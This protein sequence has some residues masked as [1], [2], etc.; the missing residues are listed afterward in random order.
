MQKHVLFYSF[1]MGFPSC[2]SD[3]R[4]FSRAVIAFDFEK[5]SVTKPL[6]LLLNHFVVVICYWYPC[7]PVAGFPQHKDKEPGIECIAVS[8]SFMCTKRA[9]LPPAVD[10][11]DAFILPRSCPYR[12]FHFLKHLPHP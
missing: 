6:A 11:S 10:I 8:K 7:P 3:P 5:K 2:H 4:V 9:Y 12:K 1:R